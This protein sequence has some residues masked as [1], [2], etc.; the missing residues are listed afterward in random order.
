MYV[1]MTDILQDAHKNNYAVMAIN[2]I[3]M[4][5]ARAVITAA[6]EMR[7]PIIVNIGMGQ[8]RKHAHANVMVPLIKKLAEEARVPVA[9]NHDHGQDLDFIIDCIQNGFSSVMI[10]A[11][12][13]PYEENVKR[14]STIV[15]LAHPHNVCVEAELGHVGQAAEGDNDKGDL[16]TDPQQAKK[17]VE[18]TGVDALAVAV[19]TAHGNYPKGFVPTLDFERLTL[20]KKTLDM[21][22]VLH[23]GS[24][25]GEENI[26]KAVACGINKINVCTDAFNVAQEAMLKKVEENSKTDYLE[27]C[28]TAEKAMKEF[29][30]DYIKVIGSDNRYFFG[31]TK[32]VGHE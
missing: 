18:E 9:L 1:S 10:D 11:S 20:L 24:G 28:I 2:S 13:L 32:V 12:S 17:F 23:G 26:R 7:S 4:E 19:G 16:Y 5:M 6:E 14:T 31:E 29:V 3:N 25:S 15:K 30:K 22:L 8:M 27:L 21:P